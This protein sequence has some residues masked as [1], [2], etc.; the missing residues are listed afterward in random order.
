M[1][2]DKWHPPYM[3]NFFAWL[4]NTGRDKELTE[5]QRKLISPYFQEKERENA[6]TVIQNA[7][8]SD[9][10][11]TKLLAL[12]AAFMLRWPARPRGFNEK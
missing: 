9:R 7:S 4:R 11:K 5:G 10:E 3:G 8:V 2:S 1:T 12:L 6:R